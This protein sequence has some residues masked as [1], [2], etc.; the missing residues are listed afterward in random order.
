MHHF[1][2][3]VAAVALLAAALL[4]SAAQA[5]FPGANGKIAFTRTTD[6]GNTHDVYVMKA[7]GS[8]QVPITSGGT[9]LEPAWSPDGKRIAFA[10]LASSVLQVRVMNA[11]DSGDTPLALPATASRPGRRTVSGSPSPAPATP[12]IQPRSMS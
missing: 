3:L 10:R 12:A 6:G 9:S 2:S 4:P 1:R 7:D 11:D 8:G 5:A